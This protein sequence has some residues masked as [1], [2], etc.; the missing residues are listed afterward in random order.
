[1]KLKKILPILLIGLSYFSLNNCAKI[2]SPPGGDKDTIPPLPIKSD[3][4]NY[5][6][7][8]NQKKIKITFDEFIKLNNAFTEFTVSPPL[9]EKPLPLVRGKA[10]LITLPAQDLDS[11][12]Y[13]LDF[14]QS[15]E[16]NNESNKL[17]NFQFVIS[18]L[19]YVDSFSVS[20][21]V[22]DAYTKIADKEQYYVLLN[23]NLSDTAFRTVIPSY[24]GRTNPEGEFNINHIAPGTYNVFALKDANNNLKYDLPSELIAFSNE[25]LYLHP[26]SFEYVPPVQD[27][28]LSVQ[29]TLQSDSILFDTLIT[30]ELASA[31]SLT[32]STVVADSMDIMVYGYSFNLF[33]FLEAEPYNLYL[34]DYERKEAEKLT[35]Y[36][37]EEQKEI[38]ELKLIQPDTTGIWNYLEKNPT[39]D[40][41]TYWLADSNLVS[42]DSIVVQI[43]HHRTDTLGELELFTDTLLFR[44]KKKEKSGE[45]TRTKGL[46]SRIGMGD[47][48]DKVADTLPY[49]PPRMS[50]QN[51]INKA[52]Q[53]LNVPIRIVANA[54]ILEYKKELVELFIMEDTIEKPANYEIVRDSSDQRTFLIHI[55]FEAAANY[56][57][58]L[59]EGAFTDIYTRTIDSTLISFATQRDD[60]YGII[61]IDIKNVT[62]PTLIELIDSK[63][64]VLQKR[65]IDSSQKLTYNFLKPGNYMFKVIYDQNNNGKWDT[66]AFD[67]LLQPEHVEYF[68]TMME[69]RSNWEVEYT[70]ELPETVT[71]NRPI[72]I[73]SDK[74]EKTIN[75]R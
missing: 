38:P 46:L 16:D 8:Y 40:T 22:L 47:D 19:P 48:D 5:S 59:H 60:F 54:P 4:A 65:M 9:E 34:D 13:T 57:L 68:H 25:P 70:W 7:N 12:T 58:K 43:I 51:N 35:I 30:S 23:K 41:L 44:F 50:L 53:D 66:G 24:L 20:G 45:V 55:D 3:P 71:E 49:K 6:V 10:V 18:K 32:D 21:K 39:N 28:I 69:V 15:I 2:G 26:D 74:D 17:P 64:K 63:E 11:L 29:P 36:F 27:T 61:Y 75:R 31:D 1:M 52:A 56:R 72:D 14:G 37:S 73:T 62:M 33:S 42:K 67:D